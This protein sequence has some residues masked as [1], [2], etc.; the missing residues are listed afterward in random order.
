[1][2]WRRANLSGE[3]IPFSLVLR[4]GNRKT[5][6][7]ANRVLPIPENGCVAVRVSI[8]NTSFGGAAGVKIQIWCAIE[9]LNLGKGGRSLAKVIC[10][11][12]VRVYTGNGRDWAGTTVVSQEEATARSSTSVCLLNH[13]CHQVDHL[14]WTLGTLW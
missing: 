10:V 4:S 11:Q 2:I 12:K 7:W 5:H 13:T 14:M 1:M 9:T 3:G 6:S 8:D